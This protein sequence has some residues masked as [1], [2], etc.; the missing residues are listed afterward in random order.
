MPD[1]LLIVPTILCSGSLHFAS[2]SHD[3]VVQDVIDSL[4]TLEEVREDVLGDLQ[5]QG[6][7]LQRIRKEHNGRAWEEEELEALGDGQFSFLHGLIIVMSIREPSRKKH[8]TQG[9]PPHSGHYLQC[10]RMCD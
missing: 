7:A 5:P 2:V 1:D 9:L 8:L 6:W 3:A 4:V 10:V